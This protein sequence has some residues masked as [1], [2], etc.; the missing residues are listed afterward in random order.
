MNSGVEKLAVELIA[1]QASG[2][3]QVIDQLTVTPATVVQSTPVPTPVAPRET[4][5]PPIHR[6]HVVRRLQRSEQT[7]EAQPMSRA[8]A[9]RI[10]APIVSAPARTAEAP[11]VK[12]APLAP[13]PLIVPAGT[14]VRVQM[15]DSIDSKHDQPGQEFAASLAAALVAG[16]KVVFPQ[17]ADARVRLVEAQQ[18]GHF[19][20]S[21]QLEL[22]LVSLND[23]G[24]NYN[25]QSGYYNV[26]AASRG[27]RTAQTVGGGAGLGALIGAIAGRGKGAAIG[28]GIGAATGGGIQALGRGPQIKIPSETK[29]DFTLK[30]PITVTTKP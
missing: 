11:R 16:P 25:V 6:Q 15:V 5:S 12:L 1:N 20:G 21:S 8:P 3:S 14:V 22:E 19:R 27:T 29:I 23:N 10:P 24:R 17:G 13:Q 26:H 18:S 30:T 4:T 9:T 28:A 2:V 7:A